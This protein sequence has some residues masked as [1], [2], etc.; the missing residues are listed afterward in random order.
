MNCLSFSTSL[1]AIFRSWVRPESPEIAEEY[2]KEMP[3]FQLRLQAKA[4]LTGYAQVYGKYNTTPYDKLQM[5]AVCILPIRVLLKISGYVLRPS[6]YCLR[7]KAQKASRRDRR[8]LWVMTA[9]KMSVRDNSYG[10]GDLQGKML[11]I[12]K[13]LDAIYSENGLTYMAAFGTCLGA[14]RHEGFIPGMMILTFTCPDMIMRNSA[15]GM[16]R[17]FMIRN[18]SL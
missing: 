6:G 7:P 17:H 15:G 13:Y 12:L 2:M 10:I 4:G 5:D 9:Q 1:R 11:D 14:I 8:R 16:E 18:I 3:E